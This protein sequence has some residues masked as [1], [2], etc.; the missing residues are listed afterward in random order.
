MSRLILLSSPPA[1]GKTTWLIN[2]W[3]CFSKQIIYLSPLKALCLEVYERISCEEKNSYYLQSFR[4]AQAV[5]DEELR[6]SYFM[7]SSFEVF[8]ALMRQGKCLK[9]DFNPLIVID[10]FHL[11]K[12]WG[13]SFR[14]ELLEVLYFVSLSG[15]D[16]IALSATY[17]KEFLSWAKNDLTLGFDEVMWINCGNMAFLH[18][19]KIRLKIPSKI[20]FY[21]LLALVL[22]RAILARETVLI[23]CA[24]RHEVRN[25]FKIFSSYFLTLMA[26]GGEVDSFCEQLK[27]RTPRLIIGTSCLGHGVNLPPLGAVFM[28]YPEKNESLRLQ[29]LSRGGRRG[30]NFITVEYRPL[31]VKWLASQLSEKV[32]HFLKI[33]KFR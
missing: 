33:I 23:F 19:P 5:F 4:Q 17:D 8:L 21:M 1:S 18:S 20:L 7:I 22:F 14:P 32:I 13:E 3:S 2:Q 16:T 28:N 31:P 10:E 29:M 30:D 9:S 15:F 11:I 12:L 6:E 24:F 26:I 25:L 27:K